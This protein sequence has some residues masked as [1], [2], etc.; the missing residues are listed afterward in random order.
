MLAEIPYLVPMYPPEGAHG[1]PGME[2]FLIE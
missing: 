2:P 1:L